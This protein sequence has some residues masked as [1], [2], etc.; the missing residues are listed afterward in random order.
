MTAQRVLREMYDNGRTQWPQLSV[1]FE[2]FQR[3]C[4]HLGNDDTSI[5]KA[6]E[7]ATD[8]YLCCACTLGDTVAHGLLKTEAEELVR[9][10]IARISKES[11]FVLETLQEFWK[12]VLLGEEAKVQDY[13]GRGPLMAWLRIVATRVAIDRNRVVRTLAERETDLRDCMAEQAFGPESTL[14]KERYYDPFRTALQQTLTGLSPKDR[15]LLRMHIVGHCSIDQIGRAYGVHR[16]TAA[17][18]LERAK[19]RILLDVRTQLE[20]MGTRLTDSEFQSVARVVGGELALEISV[21]PSNV[22]TL[23]SP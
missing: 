14:M 13:Q 4:A 10:A 23:E 3:Y 11:E 19:K 15:N 12:K 2:D 8:L 20:A 16:A 9:G 18:W 22:K 1:T 6:I 7:F 5:A 21:F 17:R